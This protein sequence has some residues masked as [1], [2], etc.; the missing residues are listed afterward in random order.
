[1]F[2]SKSTLDSDGGRT[3]VTPCPSPPRNC[4]VLRS[5]PNAVHSMCALTTLRHWRWG[6]FRIHHVVVIGATSFWN[7]EMFE[8]PMEE[9]GMMYGSVI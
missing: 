1:M 4:R 7:H 5:W 2:G 8:I 3:F 9:V 6:P